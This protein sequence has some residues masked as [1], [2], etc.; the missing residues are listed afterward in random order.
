MSFGTEHS[1]CP[2]FDTN[3]LESAEHDFIQGELLY[4][5]S[6]SIFAVDQE[7]N[8][9][10]LSDTPSISK[11]QQHFDDFKATYDY[12]AHDLLP[13]DDNQILKVMVNSKFYELCDGVLDH[14]FQRMVKV[15]KD[16]PME[17]RWIKQLALLKVRSSKI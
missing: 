2:N 10:S 7:P 8:L 17:E 3:S 9:P 6:P 1:D 16:A 12:L 4:S 5:E 14:W 13:T 11:L 15:N